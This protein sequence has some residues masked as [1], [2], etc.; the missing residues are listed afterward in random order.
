MLG[1]TPSIRQGA[2][3]ASKREDKAAP[4][5]RSAREALP[6][7]PNPTDIAMA[8]AASGKPL[9]D[10]ARR[11]LEEQAELLH[12]QRIELKLRHVGEI[13][14]AALWA[15]LAIVAFVFLA[16]IVSLVVRAARSDA[17]I[18][19]S[20][21]VPPALAARG[22]SGEVVATQVLDRLAQMEAQSDSIRAAKTYGNNWGDELK[23][24]IPNTSAT[25]EQLWRLL[26]GWLGKETR[27]SGEI[28]QTP[29]GLVLTTRVGAK[30]GQSFASKS[31]SVDE[32]TKWGAEHI[33]KSTQPYRYAVYVSR[34]EGRQN[35]WRQVLEELSTDP[36]PDERKWAFNGLNRLADSQG[37]LHAALY[38]ARRSLAIDPNMYVA[39][40]NQAFALLGLGREQ[41]AADAFRSIESVVVSD[42]FD[43]EMTGANRCADRAVLGSVTMDIPMVDK[44]AECMRSSRRPGY[45]DFALIAKANADV[46]RHDGERARTIR[47]TS[48]RWYPPFIAQAVATEAH[49][50]AAML[51]GASP[52]LNAAYEAYAKASTERA[53]VSPADR[54]ILPT[55]DWPLQAEALAIL[56]RTEQAQALIARTPLHC[57]SCLRVRG[58]V[59]KAAGDRAGAQRWFFE[60]AKQGPRLAPAFLDWGRLLLDN[61]RYA[62]AEPKIRRA[63][64]LAPNWSDPLKF[65]GDLLAAQGQHA[66]ALEKYDAALK[67]APKWQELKAARARVAA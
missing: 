49:M 7:S 17:L 39:H 16:L 36:S 60:A 8:A 61:R 25:A 59:A 41:E 32:L 23:I 38:F 15:I 12:A 56:G 22:M 42:E 28:T 24:D 51:S 43:P 65:W 48:F 6:E 63:A 33:Y 55:F 14:R 29:E 35:E 53:A 67:L 9:P 40:T 27:I 62:T 46:L 45:A 37:N 31:G 44:A 10:I 11:V 3:L 50:R 66:E 26:R 18:V 1:W 2:A 19:E 57:Y 4:R 54:A 20:F 34:D 47:P 52:Q 64:E 58:L 30:A 13:V 5:K 21:R